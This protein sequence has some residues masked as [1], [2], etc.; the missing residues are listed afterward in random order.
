MKN[1]I[2]SCVFASF[3][4]AAS[5]HIQAQDIMVDGKKLFAQAVPACSICHAMAHAGSVGE[6]G[7]SLD[8]LKP[9][10]ARVAKAL[11]NGIGQMPAFKTLTEAQVTLLSNYVA[12]ATGAGK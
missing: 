9:D 10:A 6:V 8:E 3:F 4:I 1:F 7:P 12:A 11:R 5:P 2:N